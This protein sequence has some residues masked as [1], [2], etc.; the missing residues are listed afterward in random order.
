[1]RIDL[2]K[3]TYTSQQE[4]DKYIYGSA[5]VVGL[6]CL[7]VF[8]NGD[9]N[10]YERLKHSAIKLGSAFQ[11]VNFLRDL[12]QDFEELDRSYFPTVDPNNFTEND[13]TEIIKEIKADFEI[14]KEG[15]M[16]L[17]NEAKFGV[18]LAYKYYS[19]LL[20]T[21]AKTPASII[22]EKR[23]RVSNSKKI[24]LLFQSYIQFKLNLL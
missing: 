20:N 4:I 2:T 17:P 22:K 9:L 1:M 18:F 8:V 21:I 12:K 13:K 10:E 24:I 11:K 14:A 16:Q 19:Q 23:I 15:L 5:D 6:M 3:K 7:K